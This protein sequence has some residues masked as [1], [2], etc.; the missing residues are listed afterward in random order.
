MEFDAFTARLGVGQGRIE[1][2]NTVPFSGD[3]VFVL[4]DDAPGRF[5]ELTAGD[6]AEVVQAVDLTDHDLV[7][8]NLRLR[9]PSNLPA[10]RTWEV[11]IVVDGSKRARATCLAGRERLITDLVA[12]VSK[13][14]GLHQL[15][16]RL[17]LMES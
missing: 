4:G 7:R 13:M 3:Y 11:A 10:N 8:A 16:V 9:V 14:T 15:G 17:E 6:H 2:Q 5:F 12:N 1:P